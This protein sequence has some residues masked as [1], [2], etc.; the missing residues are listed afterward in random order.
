LSFG[1]STQQPAFEMIDNVRS[2]YETI[3]Q[4]KRR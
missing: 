1:T 3:E 4:A 2:V